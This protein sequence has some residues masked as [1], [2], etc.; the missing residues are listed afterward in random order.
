MRLSARAYRLAHSHDHTQP[1]FKLSECRSLSRWQ[2]SPWRANDTR[3]L[4]GRF[5]FDER[6]VRFYSK[7][8]GILLYMGKLT[9]IRLAQS[10][11]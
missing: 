6:T 9:I 3:S 4:N 5:L 1:K 10:S 11:R 7:V 2:T 8:L